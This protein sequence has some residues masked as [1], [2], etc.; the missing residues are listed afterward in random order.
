MAPVDDEP[1]Q[2]TTIATP[3][4]GKAAAES[5]SKTEMDRQG[6]EAARFNTG[7]ELVDGINNMI[8]VATPVADGIKI[9]QDAMQLPAEEG[10]WL[11]RMINRANEWEIFN[12]MS[13][14]YREVYVQQ[15]FKSRVDQFGG[16]GVPAARPQ[17]G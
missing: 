6:K 5:M 4:A 16:P 15:A 10:V 14:E 8:A 13:P 12:S 7:Q 11:I 17:A 3:E 1:P 9:I 2:C